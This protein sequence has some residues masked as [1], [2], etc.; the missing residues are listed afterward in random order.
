MEVVIAMHGVAT[1]FRAGEESWG[2]LA[3][4][5]E[6]AVMEDEGREYV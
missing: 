1:C 6:M 5:A 3:G 4:P 2:H